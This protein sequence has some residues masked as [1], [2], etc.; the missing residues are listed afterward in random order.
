LM[1]NMRLQKSAATGNLPKARGVAIS[2]D[3]G[4]SFGSD[5]VDSTLPDPRCQGSI[6]RSSW[7][8]EGK[9]R[10]VCANVT[11]TDERKHLKGRMSL[12]E[13]QTWSA[14]RSITETWAGYSA[15]V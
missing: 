12:D 3:G 13:G 8:D 4:E 1:L 6:L 9:S 14:T 7:P 5:R 11:S 2:D 10:I 15:L